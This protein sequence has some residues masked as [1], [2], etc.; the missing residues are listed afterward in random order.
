MD[1]EQE[2]AECAE[3]I[4]AALPQVI[5]RPASAGAGGPPGRLI[6]AMRHGALNGKRL[7][8]L[9]VRQ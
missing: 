8:P 9:L 7:L 3:A 2:R 4:D 1:F 5:G 6:A